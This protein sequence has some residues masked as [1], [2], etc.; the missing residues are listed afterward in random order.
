MDDRVV[1]VAAVDRLGSVGGAGSDLVVAEAA[2]KAVDP[3]E[4]GQDIIAVAAVER[5]VA[6]AARQEVVVIAARR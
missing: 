2:D 3:D 5:V 1:A 4:V 6:L